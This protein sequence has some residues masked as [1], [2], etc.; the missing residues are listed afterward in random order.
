[1]D[2]TELNQLLDT[3]WN[4]KHRVWDERTTCKDDNR[5]DQLVWL[6]HGLSISITAIENLI[7]VNV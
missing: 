6:Q 4:A 5:I 2:K 7:R 3:I 1:M